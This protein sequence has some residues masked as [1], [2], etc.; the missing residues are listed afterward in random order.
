MKTLKNLLLVFVLGALAVCAVYA[1]INV[2]DNNGF[3][4]LTE[5]TRGEYVEVA[6]YLKSKGANE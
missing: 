2:R 3:T 6:K 4:A 1:D 5:A